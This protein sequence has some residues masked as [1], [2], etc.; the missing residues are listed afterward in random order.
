MKGA[1][2]MKT[3]VTENG[4]GFDF[5]KAFVIFFVALFAFLAISA[6]YQAGSGGWERAVDFQNRRLE[7]RS[8]GDISAMLGLRVS[9]GL[10]GAFTRN[11]GDR[12][13]YGFA[14]VMTRFNSTE[15]N[16]F[17]VFGILFRITFVVLVASWLFVRVQNRKNRTLPH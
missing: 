14:G 2:I 5:K 12:I 4:G 8:S 1:T 17:G 16:V 11:P 7:A 6:L 3:S 13:L 15:F 9:R 10:N